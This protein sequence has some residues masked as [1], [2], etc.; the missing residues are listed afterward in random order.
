MLNI[1]FLFLFLFSKVNFIDNSNVFSQKLKE[2]YLFRPEKGLSQTFLLKYKKDTNLIFDINDN[3][4]YQINIHSINCN[5]KIDFNGEIINQINYDTFTVKMDSDNNKITIKPIIDIINGEE[6][7]NYENKSCPLSINSINENKPELRIENKSD[8]FFYFQK[9]KF[10]LLNISYEIE[11]IVNDSFIALLF[12]FDKGSDFLI[13]TTYKSDKCQ[14][15]LISKAIQNSSYIYLNTK[16][17]L[18]A[19]KDCSKGSIFINIKKLDNSNVVMHFKIIEKDTIS[20]IQKNSLNYGFI[21]SKIFYQYYYME[22]FKEEEGEIM[23]H[24]KRFY[25]ELLA[26]IINKDTITVT[27]LQDLSNYPK[28]ISGKSDSKFLNYNP[29]SLKLKFD[30]NDTKDCFNGCYIIITY[31]QKISE[32]DFPLIGYEYTLLSRSWNSSDYISNIVDIPFNEH[33]IGAFE[34][35][36]I[37]H[38]YYSISIPDDAKKLIIQIE[39]NYIEGYYCEGRKRINTMK[40]MDDIR[41]LEIINNQH[42]LILDTQQFNSNEKFIT[43]AIR[44]KDYFGD[45]FSFYYFRIFAI[46]ENEILYFPMDSQL[47]NLCLPEY[48]LKKNL[49]YCYSSFENDY[50]ELATRFVVSSSNQNEYFKIYITKIYKNGN[51]SNDEKEFVYLYNETTNDIKTYLFKFEFTNEEVKNLISSLKDDITHIFPQIYSSQMF[52]IY[53]FT[54]TC[55]FTMNNNYTLIYKYV[56][57]TLSSTG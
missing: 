34:K 39:G 21:T 32:G 30:Y 35:G 10:D 38:H 1:L 24:N 33:L 15:N 16:I 18:N 13:N 14:T 8:I 22:V 40:I 31:E 19:F 52:Y 23:L 45:I 2:N 25:G 41:K 36:S 51:I 12:Q 53:N 55:N 9:S 43:F 7:E 47:G 44:P 42:E 49:Y 37:N 56:F 57:G 17:L 4:T 48:D 50:N 5:I 26:K 28:Q 29:H 20:V 3:E 6:K 27:G 46:K 11:E 54:K